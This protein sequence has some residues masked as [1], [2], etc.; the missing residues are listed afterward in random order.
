MKL[1]SYYIQ[2]RFFDAEC[3]SSIII[4]RGETLDPD[5]TKAKRNHKKLGINKRFLIEWIEN[6]WK[7]FF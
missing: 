5:I 4:V 3:L 6:L 1:A 7:R 2:G